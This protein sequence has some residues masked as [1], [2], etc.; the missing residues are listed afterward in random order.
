MNRSI[1]CRAILCTLSFRECKALVFSAG[2]RRLK[3]SKDDF[4][5]NPSL[6]DG[7]ISDHVPLRNSNSL[8]DNG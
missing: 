1:S 4:L 5:S 7:C 8:S 2:A 3:N 6:S